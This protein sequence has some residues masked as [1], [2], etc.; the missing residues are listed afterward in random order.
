MPQTALE[1]G[2]SLSEGVDL[3]AVLVRS[4]LAASNGEA[5]RQLEQRG[6]SVNGAKAEPGRMLGI[7][8]VLHGRWVLVRKGKRDWA[9]LDGATGSGV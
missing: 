5:R 2:E 8:D 4:G 1:A 6:I 9:M 3:V 7:D